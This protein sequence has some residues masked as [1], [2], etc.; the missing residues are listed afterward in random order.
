MTDD[1]PERQAEILAD[2]RD[3]LS[4]VVQS[5]ARLKQLVY[6][7][8]DK[9]D[10]SGIAEEGYLPDRV[11]AVIL[12]AY[13]RNKLILL[14]DR[15]LHDYH[16]PVALEKWSSTHRSTFLRASTEEQARTTPPDI[17]PPPTARAESNTLTASTA[18][19]QP[20]DLQPV[21]LVARG[22]RDGEE[23]RQNS[24]AIRRLR[25]PLDP[26]AAS[27]TREA[28]S[29]M[30]MVLRG[31]A[32]RARLVYS[33][34]LDDAIAKNVN[35]EFD[36]LVAAI[37]A[38]TTAGT[39]DEFESALGAIEAAAAIIYN[40]LDVALSQRLAQ[41][42]RSKVVADLRMLLEA[43]RSAVRFLHHWTL[44]RE[45]LLAGAHRMPFPCFEARADADA[46]Q[47]L[48][49]DVSPIDLEARRA[50]WM[51]AISAAAT[52]LSAGA[53]DEAQFNE[54]WKQAISLSAGIFQSI[55]T[56]LRSYP[57]RPSA[58]PVTR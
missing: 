42:G 6:I 24:L 39:D 33:D 26:A 16:H 46:V 18:P 15:A 13:E 17:T 22:L 54:V 2:L 58:P 37:D 34:V 5:D 53:F 27:G 23:L 45:M 41:V 4:P 50:A 21:M 1:L 35:A 40:T 12:W 31:T 52:T 44:C 7:A 9:L 3:V 14:V 56:M 49:D 32:E 47:V 30:L 55:D 20:L 8:F 11:F 25:R 36:H 38:A 48:L 43:W 10:V 51:Q 28:M 19:Q 57:A 29:L